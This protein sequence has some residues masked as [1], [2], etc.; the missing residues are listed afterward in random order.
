[1]YERIRV[2]HFQ[3]AAQFF[4]AFRQASGDHA[5]GF[6]AEDR[7]KAFAS[8]KN[9]VPHGLMDGVR[10]LRGSGQ[11]LFQRSVNSALAL[12]KDLIQHE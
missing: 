5:R 6:H 7:T 12:R 3:G 1:M 10:P 9:T 11:K 4:N 8:G 2:Q